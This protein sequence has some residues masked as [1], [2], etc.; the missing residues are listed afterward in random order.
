MQ[1]LLGVLFVVVVVVTAAA[2][3]A[4]A[5]AAMS[6]GVTPG[7]MWVYTFSLVG[8]VDIMSGLGESAAVC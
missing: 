5:A 6:I 7:F 8:T 4:A 1:W 3:A 2:A